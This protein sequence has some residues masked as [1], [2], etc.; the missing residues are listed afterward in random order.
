MSL[1]RICHKGAYRAQD[2]AGQ[3]GERKRPDDPKRKAE[4]ELP[5]TIIIGLEGR[6]D[7]GPKN[8]SERGNRNDVRQ[9][10]EAPTRALADNVVDEVDRDVA[11]I[12][13]NRREPMEDEKRQHALHHVIGSMDRLT[14]A[15]SHDNV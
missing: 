5:I 9:P 12:E 7:H 10:D 2:R 15:I 14:E 1:P 11:A 6:A 4:F 13:E 3:S 8:Q